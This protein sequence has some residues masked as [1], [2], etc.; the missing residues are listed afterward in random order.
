MNLQIE[1]KCLTTSNLTSCVKHTNEFS[2]LLRKQTFF[3][4]ISHYCSLSRYHVPLNDLHN[5]ISGVWDFWETMRHWHKFLSE[6]F[7]FIP[8]MLHVHS[9]IA[10]AILSGNDTTTHTTDSFIQ[11]GAWH[12]DKTFQF[13]GL[14]FHNPSGNQIF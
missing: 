10:D 13:I 7:C 11:R 14:H 8:A 4:L 9:S 5:H 1:S 3:Y 12:S 2:P 6:Y